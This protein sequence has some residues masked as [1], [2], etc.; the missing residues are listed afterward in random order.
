MA[1]RIDSGP[2]PRRPRRLTPFGGGRG[3][4]DA[5]AMLGADFRGKIVAVALAVAFDFTPVVEVALLALA[6][7]PVPPLLPGKEFKAGGRASYTIGLL[8]PP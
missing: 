5:A 1:F 2:L 6:I 4:A 3:F 7:S 8:A